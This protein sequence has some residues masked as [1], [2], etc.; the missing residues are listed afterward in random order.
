MNPVFLSNGGIGIR[1]E[2][3]DTSVRKQI[4][5]D[6]DSLL[7]SNPNPLGT[8]VYIAI[9]DANVVATTAGYPILVGSKEDEV[10][11]TAPGGGP[12]FKLPGG[13]WVAAICETGESGAITVHRVSR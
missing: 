10:M 12:G 1:L 11:L 6:G 4:V 8:T 13:T 2:P 7:F 3:G 9:G 5:G